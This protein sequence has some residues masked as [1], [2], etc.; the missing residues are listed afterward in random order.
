M[1]YIVMAGGNYPHWETPKQ[2]L[3]I[4][5]EPII[6]RTIRLLREAGIEDI[7][8]SSNN[9][10]FENLGVPVLHHEN[11]YSSAKYNECTGYWCECFYPTDEPTT[12]LFGDV[13]YSV[14]AIKTIRDYQGT[15]IMLFGSAPPFP[16]QYPKPWIE[17]FGF[18]VWD[19]EHLRRAVQEVKD[20]H[21]WGRFNREPIA[22]ET[23]NV[24]CR[25]VNSD[26]NW[27]DYNS[28]V[29]INDYTCD[30]DNP[31]EIASVERFVP[32]ITP[33]IK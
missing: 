10:A 23:W 28:Y 30:I 31:S 21:S 16:P 12:Y 1:K 11:N 6:A 27:I 15:D 13:I 29:H 33:P 20:L 24:I 9:P 8:I 19:T 2:L 22:W 14:K 26:V 25:G 32:R 7:S 4:H 3:K 17:P 5:G 18:K